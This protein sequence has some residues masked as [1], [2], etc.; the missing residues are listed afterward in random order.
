MLNKMQWS[1]AVSLSIDTSLFDGFHDFIL[2][3]MAV[4][5]AFYKLRKEKKNCHWGNTLSKA[6][7]YVCFFKVICTL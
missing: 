5:N 1:L 6:T 2:N 3:G 7:I 4:Y